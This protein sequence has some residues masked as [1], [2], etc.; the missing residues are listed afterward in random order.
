MDTTIE[1]I[2]ETMLRAPSFE[3]LTHR[4]IP[5]GHQVLYQ[6]VYKLLAKPVLPSNLFD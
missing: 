2:P 5:V 4:G 3:H 6:T 1:I